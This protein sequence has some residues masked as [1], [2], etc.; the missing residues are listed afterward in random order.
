MGTDTSN[1]GS[2]SGTPT[3]LSDTFTSLMPHD[4]VEIREGYIDVGD[5]TLHYVEAGHGPKVILLHGFPEFWFGW[6]TRFTPSPR[7]ASGPS[8]P[9]CAATATPPSPRAS[10][11]TGSNPSST[12]SSP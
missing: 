4:G 7:P 8:L 2:A 10:A 3:L 6:R 12:T 9:T 5:V 1:V 11:T